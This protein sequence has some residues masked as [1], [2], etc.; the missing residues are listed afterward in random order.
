VKL[1]ALTQS[2]APTGGGVR[3]LL[4][5]QREY[6]RA[7]SIPHVMIVPG[8]RDETI[9]DGVL[10]TCTVASP[11]MPGS[12]VYR[13]LLR[14]DKV[15]ALLRAH[16]P[17]VIEVH[18]AYNLPWTAF[19]H[20]RRHGGIVSGI[21]NTDV[22]VAY[23]EAPIRRVAGPALAACARAAAEKY[24][25]AL[26][27]RCDVVVAISPAMQQRLQSVGV[28][29]AHHVPLGVDVN[30]FSPR[31][32]SNEVRAQLGASAQTLL[33]IYAGRL[34][35]EKR[36]DLLVEMVNQL[37][38]DLDVRLVL[39]GDGPMRAQLAHAGQRVHVIPFV[40]DREQLA[41]LLSSADVYVSAMAHET[42]GLSVIEAQA[43][44]LPVVGF[45][46]GAMTDRVQA[47]EGF[48]VPGDDT[49]AMAERLCTTPRAEW[50]SMGLRAHERVTRQFSWDRTFDTLFD[51]YRSRI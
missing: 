31:H 49:A 11:L 39:V 22:P 1:C 30:A 33:L 9:A 38:A 20:R 26:Y 48:L 29:N 15:L 32:R 6:C 13:L 51:I 7:R 8:A 3:T 4:H 41:R 21:Y 45:A 37:P 19:A 35:G 12:R 17:D 16:A 34:D 42:F 10:T 24:V 14:S 36:P 43:S 18:C 5:A 47:G 28:N 2:Y 40:H 23:V 44:G 27:R 25:R 50:R 46:A